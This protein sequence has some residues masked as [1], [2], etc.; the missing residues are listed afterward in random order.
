MSQSTLKSSKDFGSETVT[1]G[2]RI[3]VRPEYLPDHSDPAKSQ[4][5]FGYRVRV[6]NEGESPVRL[7]ARRWSIVDAEGEERVVEGD[8]VIGQQPIIPPGEAFSYASYCPLGTPWGTMEGRYRMEP[9]SGG[10]AFDAVIA[11]FFLVSG[12]VSG[13]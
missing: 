5:V 11:R 9:A 10:E 3:R 7:V 8:G 1:S 2:V 12:G 4:F 6:I 13:E